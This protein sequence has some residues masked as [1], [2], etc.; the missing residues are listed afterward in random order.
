M[1]VS[2]QEQ[3]RLFLEETFLTS[4]ESANYLGITKQAIQS[5]AKRNILPHIRKGNVLLFHRLDIE[6]R[7]ATQEGLRKK[8]RPYEH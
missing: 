3:D 1:E 6:N 7:H 4:E 5:L 2:K 8:Y